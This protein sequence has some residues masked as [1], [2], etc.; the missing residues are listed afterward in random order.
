MFNKYNIKIY[1]YVM[2]YIDNMNRFN[3]FAISTCYIY[4]YLL[5]LYIFK[6]VEHL[7]F[8]LRKQSDDGFNARRNMS[9]NTH[10]I[11]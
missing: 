9:L 8:I 4:I 3:K 11:I 5:Y 2:Q 10:L 7:S 6:V 1:K